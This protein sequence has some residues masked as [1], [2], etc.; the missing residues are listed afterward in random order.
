MAGFQ[1]DDERAGWKSTGRKNMRVEPVE[2]NALLKDVER[3][4]VGGAH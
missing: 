3:P 1:K 4:P 2:R